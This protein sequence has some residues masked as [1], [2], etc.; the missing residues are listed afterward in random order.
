MY[1]CEWWRPVIVSLRNGGAEQDQI[2]LPETEMWWRYMSD[3]GRTGA[4]QGNIHQGQER[5]RT[6]AGQAAPGSSVWCGETNPG[7]ALPAWTTPTVS[8]LATRRGQIRRDYTEEYRI[9][10]RHTAHWTHW[11]SREQGHLIQHTTSYIYIFRYLDI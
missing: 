3:L 10:Y 8:L 5:V 2:S 1:D 7:P 4:Q 9:Q 11:A 6:K